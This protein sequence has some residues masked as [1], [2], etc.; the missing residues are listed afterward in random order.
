VDIWGYIAKHREEIGWAVGLAAFFA[1]MADV[2]AIGPR[3]RDALRF[4]GN[5]VAEQSTSRLTKRIQQLQDYQKR[6]SSDR[7]LYLFSFQCI[8]LT[9]IMFA[10]AGV[11]LMF[12][13]TGV[14]SADPV[15]FRRFFVAGLIFLI[16]GGGFAWE[17]LAGC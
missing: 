14:L 17:G 7:W 12:T 15:I 5:R 4:V 3:C 9:L 11:C 2:A 13:T 10:C 16:A 8:F 1:I 6:L